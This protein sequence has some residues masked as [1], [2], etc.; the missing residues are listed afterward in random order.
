MMAASQ[1]NGWVRLE[2]SGDGIPEEH[3]PHVF[4]RFYRA[5][6]SRVARGAGLGL[7]IARQI[8]ESHGGS[9][10]VECEVGEGSTFALQ[11]P[12]DCP[13]DPDA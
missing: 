10:S 6:E 13:A 3:L 7:S 9:L 12:K 8:A 2:V 5:D 4:E 1:N 11:L